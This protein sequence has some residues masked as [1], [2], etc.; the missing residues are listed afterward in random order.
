[1]NPVGEDAFAGTGLAVNEDRTIAGQ[2]AGRQSFRGAE[3]GIGV[4][5]RRRRLRNER[6][7]HVQSP[8]SYVCSRVT[9]P[10]PSAPKGM[11]CLIL[12]VMG[13]VVSASIHSAREE[14]GT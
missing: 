10:A 5:A 8:V 13:V 12:G 11:S 6:Q 9:C 7:V 4:R 1:M 14:T 3:G 2:Q